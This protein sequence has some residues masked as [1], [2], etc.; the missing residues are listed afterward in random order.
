MFV[1]DLATETGKW[2]NEGDQLV[3]GGDINEDVKTCGLTDKLSNMGMIEILTTTHG[4][5][6]PSTY[7]RGSTPI[8]GIY[9]SPTL[10][11]LRC[12]YDK[13]V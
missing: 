8:D 1:N 9:V 5:E 4:T 10:Q 6:G 2:L 11:G 7:N 3:I 13:F 12:G